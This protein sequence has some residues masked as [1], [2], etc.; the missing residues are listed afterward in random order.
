MNTNTIRIEQLRD[1]KD[2]QLR[3]LLNCFLSEI[4]EPPLSPEAE[5]ALARAVADGRIIFFLALDGAQAVGICSVSPC[6]ST[7][8]CKTSGVFD[9]FYVDPAYR[10]RGVARRLA[11]A[12]RRW[13]A[14]QNYAS[15][16]VGCSDGD[17]GM[18]QSL[19]F[20]IRLGTMLAAEP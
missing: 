14:G 5:S 6:F 18:Y 15:L 3:R 4:G 9:D 13:C 16:T 1:G 11:D 17:V 12:A 19:G 2:R 7:F 8:G 20:G 10:H